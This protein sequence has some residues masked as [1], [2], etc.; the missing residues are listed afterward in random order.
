MGTLA[1][2]NCIIL[3]PVYVTG[4]INSPNGDKVLNDIQKLTI[5]NAINDVDRLYVTLFL[6]CMNICI[7]AIFL[8]KLKK[9]IDHILYTSTADD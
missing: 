7:F 2:I 9:K 8:I 4:E 3:I 1:F 5:A 6:I